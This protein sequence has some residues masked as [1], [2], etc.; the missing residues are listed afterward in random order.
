M[1]IPLLKMGFDVDGLD[2][3]PD[4]LA[5][6]RERAR[7]EGFEPKLYQQAMHEFDASRQ[8]QTIFICD[9]F[10]IG[11]NRDHDIETLRRCY[12]QLGDEGALCFNAYLPY[13]DEKWPMWALD[14]RQH[15]PEPWPERGMRKCTADGDEIELRSRT[16]DLDPLAQCETR[17]IRAELWCGSQLVRTEEHRLMSNMYFHN[18]LVMMLEA[19]GFGA[20]EMVRA[21]SGEPATSHDGLVVFVARK[22][23]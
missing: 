15:L 14:Q 10:G 22:G 12:R 7:R 23:A 5:H 9:S 8:Y 20:V 21:Y 11:G 1:L 2:Y 18:E 6:C 16:V 13:G 4:M 19:A 3:S 17:E